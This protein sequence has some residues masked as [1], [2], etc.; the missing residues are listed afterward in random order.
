MKIEVKPGVV[1]LP[2]A[3][4]GVRVL[5]VLRQSKLDWT[6]T[7]TS[8]RDGTH[9]GPSDPHHSGEAFDLRTHGL[10]ASQ[11][12]SWVN[13]LMHELGSAFYAFLEAPG[14]SNEHIHVQKK[15]GTTYTVE[16]L[17]ATS[18]CSCLPHNV[19]DG[20]S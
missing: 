1:L 17:L 18:P 11:K 10:T 15:R 20:H 2:L 5:E 9:S 7:I 4:A 12:A 14:A 13:V 19:V 8:G 16:Q 3:P 6:C